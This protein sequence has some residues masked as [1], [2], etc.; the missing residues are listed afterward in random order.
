MKV[1]QREIRSIEAHGVLGEFS[2]V[3]E[4]PTRVDPDRMRLIYAPNGRGKTNFLRAVSAALTPTPDSLQSL[5]EIPFARLTIAFANGGLISID[6]DE[7][8][9]GQFTASASVGTNEEAFSISVDPTE[10]SG[11]MYRRIWDTRADFSSYS[12]AVA[13]LSPGQY[14]LGTTGSPRSLQMKCET[15]S[16]T[17]TILMRPH[18]DDR[19]LSRGCWRQSSAC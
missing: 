9:V 15:A 12:D 8:V 11:R 14:L 2:Y 18:A 6:R 10:L 16:G 4:Y 13:Q 17:R 3:V 19:V 5:I 1:T 7:D